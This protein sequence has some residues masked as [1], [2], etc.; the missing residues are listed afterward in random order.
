MASERL[1]L[2]KRHS[3]AMTEA[4]KAE[5]RLEAHKDA[6]PCCYDADG[7]GNARWRELSA[8]AAK[9]RVAERKLNAEVRRPARQEAARQAAQTRAANRAAEERLE[10][11]GRL[12]ATVPAFS[13]SVERE[14]PAQ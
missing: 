5:V 14:V 8:A 3:A 9:A 11:G 4:T 13:Y 6:Y 7:E 1:E 2:L 12:T 10:R